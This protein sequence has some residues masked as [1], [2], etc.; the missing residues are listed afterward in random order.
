MEV[1]MRGYI[2]G[3]ILIL[4]LAIFTG[5]GQEAV[6]DIKIAEQYARQQ[7]YKITSRNANV[8][9]YVL[10]KNKLFGSSDS[11][12]Y[13]QTWG[14]QEVEPDKYFGKEISIYGFTVKSHPL[15]AMYN[16]ETNI[17]VMMCEGK[18]IGGTSFPVQGEELLMGWPYSLDGQ[19]LEEVTGMSYQEWSEEWEKKYGS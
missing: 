12:P 16:R 7:G 11:M 5:C 6:D 4:A 1:Q 8:Q 14:V 3:T 2:L 17:S 10:D 19:T 9:K 15:E 18:V 13:Q